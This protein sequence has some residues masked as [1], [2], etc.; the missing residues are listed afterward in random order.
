MASTD[1]PNE[2]SPQSSIGEFGA[3][4]WLVDDMYERYLA[5]PNSV[6]AAWHDFFADYRQ[7]ESGNGAAAPVRTEAPRPATPQ[8]TPEV[9]A[10]SAAQDRAEASGAAQNDRPPAEPV[11][12][13]IAAE[14]P[15]PAEPTQ[16]QAAPAAPE[17][18][19]SQ[20]EASRPE[21]SQPSA[22]KTQTDKQ[23]TKSEAGKGDADGGDTVVKLRGAAARVV[24]NMESLAAA[25]RPRPAC[26]RSRPSCSPTTGS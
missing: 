20:P 24:A 17:R 21:A 5:D 3:N 4:E 13:R 26:A 6:D 19:A 11:T 10:A 22:S 1:Q 15:K 12:T 7:G 9:D 23:G 8:V 25:S 18:T 14:T 16:T 2:T